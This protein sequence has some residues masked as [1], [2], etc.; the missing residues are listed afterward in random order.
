MPNKCEITGKKTGAG[1]RRSHSK[2]VTKR[3]FCVNLQKKRLINP[4]TG[5]KMILILS[6]KALK[7]LKKWDK[8]GKKYDLRALV[9]KK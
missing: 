1:N 6:T 9:A 7:T 5:K 2:I 8:E 4:V 3:K